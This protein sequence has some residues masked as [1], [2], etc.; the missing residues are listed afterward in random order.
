MSAASDTPDPLTRANVTIAWVIFANKPIYPLYVWYLVGNGVMASLGTLVAAPFFL[1]I[2]YAAGRSGPAARIMLPLIGA[3][4]TLFETKLF[5]QGSGTQLFFAAC[6]MLAAVS[7]H[8]DEKWWQRGVAIIVFATF[9]LS[10]IYLG[11]P[12][13]VWSSDDLGV[14]LN[15]NSFAL[16]CLTTFIALRFAGQGR[17]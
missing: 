16:A 2:P 12:L 3:F 17:R 10:R 15:L 1:A 9:A 6:I 11:T 14:L 7:F 5:G 8:P 4:D 13:H